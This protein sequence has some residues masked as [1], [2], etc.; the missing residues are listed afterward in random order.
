MMVSKI[1]QSSF[2][3]EYSWRFAFLLGFG[4]SMIGYFV[5]RRLLE[6]PEFLAS[7]KSK[8]KFPLLEG[9][10]FHSKECLGTIGVAAANGINFYLIL[11]FLPGYVNGLISES[12]DYFP[13]ITTVIL[14][15]LSPLF[16]RL[17]DYIGR[18]K[19]LSY[20]L[21]GTA[22][23]GFVGIQLLSI[24]PSKELAISFFIIHAVIASTITG[25][26]NVFVV[27][28]FPVKY[29]YSCSSL[30]YSLGMGI[31]GGTSP[32][33]ASLLTNNYLDNSA[34][35]LSYYMALVPI[36]GFFAMLIAEK[37]RL[38]IQRYQPLQESY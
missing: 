1:V 2:V 30:C 37:R 19:M 21:L 10:K 26:A 9:I 33:V 34:W 31:V 17:S 14:V 16:S 27:E 25:T 22:F 6:T 32:M 11:V 38:K 5:R 13:I 12:V 36:L 4:L 18:A 35:L 3:P 28:I 7:T 29:R 24:Y 8:G 20:G 15:I 23:W